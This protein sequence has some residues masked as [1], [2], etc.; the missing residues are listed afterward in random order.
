M[1]LKKFL[2]SA[3]R[4]EGWPKLFRRNSIM[5][6]PRVLLNPDHRMMVVWSPKSACTTVF[7]WFANTIGKIEDMKGYK[8]PHEYRSEAYYKSDLHLRGLKLAPRN[9]RIVRVIRDPYFRAAS[10]YRHA[11]KTRLDE[12]HLK[13]A[14]P[15][16]D[17]R[18][19]FSF[20]QF[21]DYIETL[22]LDSANVHIRPQFH[23]VEAELRPEFVINISRQDLF[24]ELNKVEE[25]FALPRTDFHSLNWLHREADRKAKPGAFGGNE[26]DVVPFD[27]L[28]ARGQK[29][30]PTYE[31][32]LTPR[33]R[34]RIETLYARDFEAYA[35]HL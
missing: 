15:P 3:I 32:L 9:Y 21:L 11:L 22:Q 18:T 27:R 12:D 33:A 7:V 4:M 30:W 16:L 20:M 26:A 17:R 35:D 2:F 10:I 24:T 29:P 13:A 5:Q 34:A 6:E 25:A 8:W 23:P 31:Q 28:A 1:M 14:S 19:G